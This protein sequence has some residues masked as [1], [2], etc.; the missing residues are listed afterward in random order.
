VTPHR[1]IDFNL[2]AREAAILV[3]ATGA[4]RDLG[5]DDIWRLGAPQPA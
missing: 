3:D 2:V 5:R 4:T 1:A